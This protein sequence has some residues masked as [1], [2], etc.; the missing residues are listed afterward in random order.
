MS[1]S[2]SDDYEL[3]GS[4]RIGEYFDDIGHVPPN[5][6]NCS[7]D[8]GI[9]DVQSDDD[10]DMA[11]CSS[12]PDEPLLISVDSLK[13][14]FFETEKTSVLRVTHRSIYIQEIILEP[15]VIEIRFTSSDPDDKL[16]KR[17]GDVRGTTFAWRVQLAGFIETD[18]LEVRERSCCSVVICSEGREFVMRKQEGGQWGRLSSSATAIRASNYTTPRNYGSSLSSYRYS[19]SSYTPST[20]PTTAVSPAPGSD[21]TRT[22][23]SMTLTRSNTTTA[24]NGSALTRSSSV[25]PGYQRSQYTTPAASRSSAFSPST[26]S[27]GSN[28]ATAGLGVRSYGS[29]MG[30][31]PS[32]YTLSAAASGPPSSAVVGNAATASAQSTMANSSPPN[33][34]RSRSSS[35]IASYRS[36]NVAQLN[37]QARERA[38]RDEKVREY[39]EWEERERLRSEMDEPPPPVADFRVKYG[40]GRADAAGTSSPGYAQF[41]KSLTTRSELSSAAAASLTRSEYTP[42]NAGPPPVPTDPPRYTPSYTGYKPTATVQPFEDRAVA[43]VQTGFTGLRN[44]GNTCFMNATLQMLV[45]NIELKTYFLDRHYKLDVNPN[46]PLGFRGRLADAF[47]EFM[48]LMWNCQNRAIEPAKIKELVAEKASQFANFAQHDAHEFLSFLLDGLHEDLNRVKAKPLTTT[49]EGDGR[50]DVD[51]SNEAWY[52][53]TLRNDSIFVDLFHGQLKSRLQCPKCDRVSITFDPFVYLPVPFP[54]VKKS[55]TLWFWPL[56]PLLKPVEVTVQYSPEGTVQD[57]LTALSDLVRVPSKLLRIVEVFSHRIQKVFSPANQASEICTGDVLYVFQVHDP[58]DC[59]EPVIEL[60]IVQRQLYSSTLRYACNECGRSTGRLKAC[61]ACYN[62]YYCNKEC[63]LSNWNTGGHR[64]E[65]R[66]RTTADHVGQPFMVSLPKSQL[67]YHQLIRVLE[68]RCRFSVDIF[69]PPQL[70]ASSEENDASSRESADVVSN[71]EKKG[72]PTPS[73]NAAGAVPR[74]QSVMPEPRK[75]PEFKMF[76]VRKLVD[77]VHVLGDT[78]VD[79]KTGQPLDLETGTYLSIN[80]Y[81]LRNGRPF[82][83]VENRRNLQIDHERTEQLAKQMRKSTSGITGDPTLQDMLGMFSE[84][85]RLK[86]EESWYCNKCRDHVEAT[87]KL[88]LF[89]LPPILIVQLKRFVYTATY[90]AM[91]RRSKDERR[92][93]YPVASLDMSPFLAETAPMGQNT[94]YD[95]TGVVCHSGSSYFGHYVSIGRLAGF[96]STDTIVDWRLFDDSIVSKQ[97][98]SNVQSD[99]A[100]LLFYKQRGVPTR[101]IFRKHYSCDPTE[102]SDTDAI[103]GNPEAT[104]SDSGS[105]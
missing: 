11:S 96:D 91:H 72:S 70:S 49:V 50:S 75:K 45:N 100:Y 46:N 21:G 76:L 28:A 15:D 57:I 33:N 67:T 53:H 98:V 27:S 88:E 19:A 35:A 59:N 82:M 52:N 6:N 78:I 61:E 83:S 12:Y 54:K 104:H 43:T 94:V 16:L 92:V 44:I 55:Q 87:K 39:K 51:V 20:R 8:E 102:N 93:I 17:Y 86:P 37:Q 26:F 40:K 1:G 89:R 66:R 101:S 23:G 63:Q 79:D 9:R 71:E 97:S 36:V 68:A 10:L 34:I 56:D 18:S 69:Q 30:H 65:C 7:E 105:D 90:Q 81:N 29:S 84:T 24:A 103:N 74:R 58:A 41:A 85:E 13:F 38:E 32:S 73:T 25:S 48:R 80:W 64:D 14:G 2:E 31:S 99:D 4:M 22:S 5:S 60:L 47:A 77:Q 95:L 42:N 3:D 62:A